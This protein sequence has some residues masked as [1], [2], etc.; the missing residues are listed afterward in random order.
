M[1]GTAKAG[2]C[3]C[4]NLPT[5]S[6]QRLKLAVYVGDLRCGYCLA[7]ENIACSIR[8]VHRPKTVASCPFL[9]CSN[10]KAGVINQPWWE[11]LP[12]EQFIGPLYKTNIYINNLTHTNSFY[13]IPILSYSTTP[14]SFK[15]A[16]STSPCLSLSGS[17]SMQLKIRFFYMF[18]FYSTSTSTSTSMAVSMSMSIPIFLFS[19]CFLIVI[20]NFNPPY[21]FVFFHFFYSYFFYFK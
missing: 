5:L 15:E 4:P 11:T 2:F 12:C 6:K 13:V 16:S 19:H 1:G 20:S 9:S 7:D 8:R 14:S 17:T 10:P 3:T 21:C 18:S